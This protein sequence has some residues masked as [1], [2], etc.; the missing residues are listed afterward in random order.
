MEEA[1]STSIL[2]CL[3]F[4]QRQDPVFPCDPSS[5]FVIPG[6]SFSYMLR[7]TDG[8]HNTAHTDNIPLFL[9]TV[10]AVSISFSI[11]NPNL[12]AGGGRDP[13]RFLL[14]YIYQPAFQDCQAYSPRTRTSPAEGPI[15]S[16]VPYTPERLIK[17]TLVAFSVVKLGA[18]D[19]ICFS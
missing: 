19:K 10:R 5:C 2:V 16:A 12:R 15:Q 13:S 14:R 7:E 6:D 17:V 1:V 18:V 9:P 8:P 11:F 3:S 4:I